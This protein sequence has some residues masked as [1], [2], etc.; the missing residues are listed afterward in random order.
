MTGLLILLAMN[1][2]PPPTVTPA[3]AKLL[4]DHDEL[5][6]RAAVEKDP[7][8]RD[9]LAWEAERKLLEVDGMLTMRSARILSER[10]PRVRDEK[11]ADRFRLQ[12]AQAYTLLLGR[13]DHRAVDARLEW[14]EGLDR[15]KWTP[16]QSASLREALSLTD[17]ADGLRQKGQAGKAVPLARK[18]LANFK[19]V[20][21]DRHPE[22]A[23]ALNLLAILH[24]ALG[25]YEAA[26]PLHRE[27]LEINARALGHRHLGTARSLHNLAE[28]YRET[29]RRRAALLHLKQALPIIKE[30]RGET[31]PLYATTLNSL[32]QLH[33]EMGDHEAALALHLRAIAI[34][35]EAL[36]RKHADYASSLNNLALVRLS[37]GDPKAALPLLEEAAAVYK[38][39]LGEGHPHYAK[40]LSNL[41]A[42]HSMKGDYKAALPLCIRVEALRKRSLGVRH[43]D[44]AASVHQTA[45]MHRKLG[46]GKKAL[47]LY[48]K[49]LALRKSLLGERHPACART[50]SALAATHYALGDH[51]AALPLAER[52]LNL[53]FS[54]L[55][56]DA[57]V[58]SDLQ[59]LVAARDA[60]LCLDNRLLLPD[61]PGHP[62]AAEH[63]L[64]WKGALLI[65]Q[66]RSRLFLR[67]ADDPDARHAAERLRS[68]TRRLV[69]LRAS[70]S[71]RR[72]QLDAAHK[73]LA[74][75]QAETS[76]LSRHFRDVL[77][78]EIPSAGAVAKALPEGAV[79]VD[80]LFS[81]PRLFAFVHRRGKTP[82]RIALAGAGAVEDAASKWRSEL[83]G[84]RPAPGPG[85]D[86]KK[87]VWTPLKKH[88]A[89][90]NVILISPD[91]VLGTVPFAALPGSKDGTYLIEDV[92]IASV[93]V[94]AALPELMGPVREGGRL[95]PSLLTVGGVDY[96]APGAALADSR[97]APADARRAWGPLPGTAA[98]ARSVAKSF[99]GRFKG[100]ELTALSEGK[101]TAG[102]I[103]SALEKARYAHLATHGFFA[104][105]TVKSAAEPP[106]GGRPDEVAPT[107]WH[108][109]LLS[110]LVFAGA[111][112]EPGPGEEDGV[113]TALEVSEM[114]LTKLE[115]AVLSACETGLGKVAGG[116]GILGM[117]RAFQAAGARSV[118]SS[119][120]KVDDE[121]TRQLMADFYSLA[122][123]PKGA[124][125]LAEA[126]RRAQMAMM[127]GKTL[128][129]KPRG[130]G[131]VPEKVE[132]GK[133]GRL[134]PYYWA[135]F[136]LSGDWR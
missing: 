99:T 111:N 43:P 84:G 81:G 122:W 52:A 120:W 108:P 114:D 119:L 7:A 55:R 15:Q 65:R 130:V 27:A 86:L 48:E 105:D 78:K 85:R 63:V 110:G 53:T 136:V 92:A 118:I 58:L 30:V 90:A 97:G 115:L 4:R 39:T 96:A 129:G 62:P 116:E 125:G 101:A 37:A 59:Q 80:Y 20:L 16:A 51:K 121:A 66:Q 8:R 36:G 79:L 77:E 75:A 45:D 82:V 68:A 102:A 134:P 12:A 1:A 135:A 22:C 56:Q 100:G 14:Q 19:A 28:L 49:A 25:E 71:A 5:L 104:A 88:I 35:K 69:A 127:F 72:E 3:Q 67:I 47:G 46:E 117:Q 70:S 113:L 124:A 26:L 123:A 131:K 57:A 94:P 41:A 2:G 38:A 112:R 76:R 73:E 17:Q 61:L 29:G 98:E 24:Q 18:A 11:I 132:K 32:G 40:C 33:Y 91:G 103:R 21:G 31:S 95:A 6:R 93:P 87:L 34:R 74:E 10:A 109:L 50:L 133:G 106:R 54:Q 64:A 13:W 44:Y 60:R 89:G 83:H 42:L 128:D 126:L 107:G 23:K 9:A